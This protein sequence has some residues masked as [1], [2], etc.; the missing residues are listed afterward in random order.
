MGARWEKRVQKGFPEEPEMSEDDEAPKGRGLFCSILQI[1]DETGR[2]RETISRRIS[3]GNL[4]PA[5]KVRSHPVYR[6]RDV[7][8]LLFNTGDDGQIDIDSLEPNTRLAWLRGES[9]KIS[10]AKEARTLIPVVEFEAQ[11]AQS[12]KLVAQCIE[13]IPDVLERDCGM[14]PEDVAAVEKHLDNLRTS[15]ADALAAPEEVDPFS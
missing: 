1:A 5:G 2:T 13:T 15:L 10:L 6:L 4:A 9:E 3:Q 7:L 14:R 11:M 8:P 12:F